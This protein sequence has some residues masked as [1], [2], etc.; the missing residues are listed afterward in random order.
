MFHS[1]P[2][3]HS[4]PNYYCVI[5]YQQPRSVYDALSPTSLHPHHTTNPFPPCFPSPAVPLS[6]FRHRAFSG[7]DPCVSPVVDAPSAC[8]RPRQPR[9][10][11]SRPGPMSQPTR[12]HAAF[13][14]FIKAMRAPLDP[15]G[16]EYYCPSDSAQLRHPPPRISFPYRLL[17]PRI[18]M[19]LSRRCN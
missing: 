13:P 17:E 14:H 9:V 10:A 6:S 5:I 2:R 8:S 11:A 18:Q 15:P 12:Q 1:D 3:M 16:L 4:M 7:P 19:N